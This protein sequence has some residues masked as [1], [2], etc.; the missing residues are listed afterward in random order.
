VCEI[1][2]KRWTDITQVF[3]LKA[4][5]GGVWGPPLKQWYLI[6]YEVT[7]IA[8]CLMSTG[9]QWTLCGSRDR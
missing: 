1:R 7:L 5:V 4:S 6:L 2:L 3:I 9:Q 8:M